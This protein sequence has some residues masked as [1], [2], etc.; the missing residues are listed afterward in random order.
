MQVDDRTESHEKLMLG[1]SEVFQTSDDEVNR[2]VLQEVTLSG[3]VDKIWS[4]EP[5]IE[6]SMVVQQVLAFAAEDKCEHISD[7]VRVH[8]YGMVL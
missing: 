4:E 5:T 2:E 6:D 3:H 7:E 8:H 1:E